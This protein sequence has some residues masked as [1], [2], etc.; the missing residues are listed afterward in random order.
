MLRL[1]EF[2]IVTPETV[3]RVLDD[4]GERAEAGP[5]VWSDMREGEEVT[6]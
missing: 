3:E 2:D 5:P 6:A 1:N 4:L